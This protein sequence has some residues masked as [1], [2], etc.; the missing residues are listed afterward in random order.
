MTTPLSVAIDAPAKI[1]L[2]LEILGKRDDGFHEIRTV[3][4]MLDFADTLHVYVGKV[5]PGVWT[6]QDPPGANLVTRALEIFR[7]AVPRSPRLGW[8]IDKRLP[9]ASGLGGGSADAA[10][11]LMAANQLA[12]LPLETSG[13][14]QLAARLGSD[15]PFFLGAPFA[16]ASG[17]GTILEDLLPA[18]LDVMLIVPDINIPQKTSTLYSRVRP[19]DYSDGSQVAE[20]GRLLTNNQAPDCQRLGN[21]FTRPL[22]E[23]EPRILELQRVISE[24]GVESFGLSGAGPAHYVLSPGDRAVEIQEALVDTFGNWLTCVQTQ[25]RIHPLH[26]VDMNSNG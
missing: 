13:L 3:M 11:A 24:L 15:I 10:A 14:A 21:A 25:T 7:D 22:S 12:G 16:I 19:A 4:A 17:R 5:G 23:I 20:V 2:G 26:V 8:K 9:V 18:R 1:N 6:A